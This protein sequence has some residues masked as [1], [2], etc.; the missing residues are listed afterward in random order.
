MSEKDFATL[1]ENA[2]RICMTSDEREQQRRSFVWGNAN[3]ENSAVT[4]SVV[5][6]VADG[7]ARSGAYEKSSSR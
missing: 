5:N 2:K 3:I 1:V 6:E 7:M 4:R